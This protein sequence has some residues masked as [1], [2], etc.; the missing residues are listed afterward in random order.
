MNNAP[1]FVLGSP[2]SG[3]SWLAQVLDGHPRLFCGLELDLVSAFSKVA[4][5][6][7][8]HGSE[9]RLDAGGP[10]VLRDGAL[11][12]AAKHVRD[13]ALYEL[14]RSGK[15]RFGDKTPSYA[16]HMPLLDQLFPTSQVV[17][18][19]R[20]GREVA[21]SILYNAATKHNWRTE[22]WVPRSVEG[23][24]AYWWQ[25]VALAQ[26]VGATWGPE[27]YHEV[28]YEALMADP[29]GAAAP[30]LA[31]L[32]EEMAPEVE[33]RLR[34]A[35][36]QPRSWASGLSPRELRRFEAVPGAAEGLRALG[37]A[38]RAVPAPPA[39]LTHAAIAAASAAF[40]AGRLDEALSEINAAADLGADEVPLWGLMARVEAAAGRGAAAADLRVRVLRNFPLN[41]EVCAELLG[42]AALPQSVFAAE[43]AVR[44]G[45]PG[46][47][48]AALSAWML[49]RGLDEGG[50]A[51]FLSGLKAPATPPAAGH[52]LAPVHRARA[53]LRLSETDALAPLITDLRVALGDPSAAAE[54]RLMLAELGIVRE[55]PQVIMT[56]RAAVAA[57]S[58]EAAVRALKLPRTQTSAQILPVAMSRVELPRVRDAAKGWLEGRG[59]DA[60][61]AN[62]MLH[63]L[64]H[65]AQERLL[66]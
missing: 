56:L 11:T 49:A 47:L 2:R 54:A 15:P 50:A 55:D 37:Y 65:D 6:R 9:G 41:A 42:Q 21:A 61:A 35:K 53:A 33:A 44:H 12:L 28:R 39:A 8:V 32:G 24:A 25:H 5:I 60:D 63:A 64:A 52:A 1:F 48:R 46:A 58:T 19:I 4:R 31:F 29:L 10:V 7:G 20:D 45:A 26:R 43:V 16:G 22:E 23:A 36:N 38:P 62:A 30:V 3:T 17:H 18:I 51:A 66:R 13:V 34:R 40:A 27:R 14:E 57:G 59:L